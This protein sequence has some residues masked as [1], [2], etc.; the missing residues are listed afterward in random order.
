MLANRLLQKFGLV[1]AA[2]VADLHELAEE[3]GRLH[4]AMKQ[5]IQSYTGSGRG[6]PFS[7]GW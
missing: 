6:H 1:R 7:N 4:E 3:T 5:V 2:E